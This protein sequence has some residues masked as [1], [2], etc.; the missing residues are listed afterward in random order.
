MTNKEKI[1]AIIEKPSSKS[2]ISYSQFITF[3]D[4]PK[5]FEKKYV[6]GNY[7]SDYNIHLVFGSSLHFCIQHYVQQIYQNP[8]IF[9]NKLDLHDYLYTRLTTNYQD[10]FQKNLDTHFSTAEELKEF[11]EDGCEIL[12]ELLKDS[13]KYFPKHYEHIGSELHLISQVSENFDVNFQ[14][15]IDDTFYDTISDKII[16]FDYKTSTKGWN[17]TTKSDEYK[18]AQLR[19]YKY[20]ISKI[21]DIKLEDIEVKFV[22]LK[23]KIWEGNTKYESKRISIFEPS[24]GKKK[25]TESFNLIE[26][27]VKNNFNKNGTH[28]KNFERIATPSKFACNFCPFN[29]ECEFA[30]K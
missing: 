8:K 10:T 4:C 3:Y 19:L 14:A 25:I 9:I 15:Y 29:N 16:L 22:I 28:N 7:K 27:F 17:E 1:T 12:T 20:F 23:R 2:K 18:L 5:K 6:E 30:F 11:Y 26:N 21:F 13:E 24:Q